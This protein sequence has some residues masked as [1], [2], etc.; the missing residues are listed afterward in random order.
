MK[1]PFPVFLIKIKNNTTAFKENMKNIM[2]AILKNT[3]RLK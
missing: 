3:N 1:A 2:E